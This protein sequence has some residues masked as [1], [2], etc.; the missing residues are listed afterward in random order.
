MED[1]EERERYYRK[2]HDWKKLIFWRFAATHTT[3]LGFLG[4]SLFL[5]VKLC[6]DVFKMDA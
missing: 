3:G 5:L 6:L 4:F 2:Q 1:D